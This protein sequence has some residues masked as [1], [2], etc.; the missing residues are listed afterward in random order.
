[1]KI[2]PYDTLTIAT[3]DSLSVVL[4]RLNANVE[5]IQRLRLS[6]KHALYQGTVTD[7]GFQISRIINYKNSFFLLVKGQ[8]ETQFNQT[9]IHVKISIHPF[10][11]SYLVFFFLFWYSA[12]VPIVLT[13]PL[14]E[15]MIPLFI[16]IPIPSLFIIWL[17]FWSEAKRNRKDLSA[18]IQGR[19]TS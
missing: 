16:G 7:L 2:I 18:I 6:R 10:V 8:F 11:I 14:L 9:L 17:A 13:D 5:P 12:F 1:M 19:S 15:H 4:E 3:P